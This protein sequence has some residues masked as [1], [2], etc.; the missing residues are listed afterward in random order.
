M[1]KKLQ[2]NLA[3]AQQRMKKFADL[4]RTEREFV[5]GDMVY[6]KMQPYRETALG[7]RNSLKLASKWYGPFRITKRVGRV[8]YKL[9]LP[10]GTQLHDV[11]HV[12]Q[13]KKHLGRA[14]VPNATLPLLTADGKV[15]NA[16][17]SI[18]QCRQVPRSVGAYDVAVPQWL[19]H[20]ENLSPAEA[21]W[22]D[23]AYIHATFKDS[24]P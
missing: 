24:K 10:T 15:K 23:A 18:L 17:L 21:T 4:H 7:L 2:Q 20:W 19:I 14:A 6:L 13:L 3:Q 22:E 5:E 12:N 11:F 16:P 8:A 9:Q 1:I